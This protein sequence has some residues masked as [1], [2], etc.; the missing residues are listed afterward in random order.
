MRKNKVIEEKT[1]ENKR[2][3]E[4]IPEWC[5]LAAAPWEA[6]EGT[7]EMPQDNEGAAAAA[8][9]IPQPPC[10]AALV[11]GKK[12]KAPAAGLSQ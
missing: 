2:L 8:A 3:L 9:A 5:A 12:R 7:E 10:S 1:A 6:E 4:G 11:C